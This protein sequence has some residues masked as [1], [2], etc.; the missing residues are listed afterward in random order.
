[1]GTLKK[2]SKKGVT[3]TIGKDGK[4]YYFKEGKRITQTKVKKD[5]SCKKAI[6]T[7]VVAKKPVKAIATRVVAKKPV[8]K[9]IAKKAMIKKAVA[10]K[11]A[12]MV[13]MAKK[14]QSQPIYIW[15]VKSYKINGKSIN[16]PDK[17]YD[18]EERYGFKPD[19]RDIDTEAK[20]NK[21]YNELDA[22]KSKLVW[23]FEDTHKSISSFQQQRLTWN[24]E[25]LE[26]YLKMYPLYVQS[27]VFPIKM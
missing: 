4:K 2:P 22:K 12:K 8:K 23:M 19:I 3:C 21:L 20:I 18:F 26:A 17:Y 1:M 11:P 24:K 14:I 7:R 10:K 27:Y 15:E 5:V 16:I 9:A 13:S 6:A 25:Q